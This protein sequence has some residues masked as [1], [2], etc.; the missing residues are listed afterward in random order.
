[1]YEYELPLVRH[2][3]NPILT[4]ETMPFRCYTVMNSG[5]TL[6]NGQVLLLLRVEY[7]D[8]TTH[9]HTA[10][11]DD[12]VHFTVNPKEIQYPL[13]ITEE[14][15]GAGHRFDIRITKLDDV[16]YVTHAVWLDGMGSCIGIAT[17]G[18]FENFQ[19]IPYL[20]E[21]S[22]RNAVLFP[23]KINGMYVR[24]DRPQDMD[25]TGGMWVSH[26]PDLIFWGKSLPINLPKTQWYRNKCGA[27]GIPI[28]TG[29]GWLLIYHATANT[30]ST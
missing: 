14:H 5:A 3:E 24:I 13:T 7:C 11:S 8:R 17:T 21:P 18:D 4:P 23:E 19:P 9:F 29:E 12:G 15:A 2:P 10:L 25:G 27:G 22:N 28:K 16:Y 30:C 1:M 26:S 20:S 6:Y